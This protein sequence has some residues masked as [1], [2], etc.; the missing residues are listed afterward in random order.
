MATIK[1]V[2]ESYKIFIEIKYPNHFKN[3]C[4]RLE[5]SPEGARAEAIL[6]SILRSEFKNVKLGEDVST[7]GVDFLCSQNGLNILFEVTSLEAEAV[8]KQSGIKNRVPDN[9]NAGCFG[10]VTHMFRTKASSKASQVSG[11][12]IPSVVA[13]TTEHI[14]GSFLLGPHGAETLLTSDTMIRVPLGPPIDNNIELSTDLK[15]SVFFKYNKGNIE[16]CRK[17]IS[18]ILLISIN[19]NNINCVG[20]LHPHPINNFPIELLPTVPFVRIKKWPPEN[21][22]IETEWVLK[23][24]NAASFA[25]NRVELL[26]VELKEL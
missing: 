12:N 6:F 1:E 18:C 20:V 15:N 26:S 4:K 7:G 24:P 2:I 9:G 21:N 14:D 8:A 10:M 3:Y 5:N 16:A 13:I 11:H 19:P 23:N 17:S 22:N 25:L